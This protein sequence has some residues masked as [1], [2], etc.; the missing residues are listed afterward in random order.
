[1]RVFVTG[2]SGWIGSAVCEELLAHKHEVVG[3]ARTEESAAALAGRGITPHAGSLDDP[4]GLAAALTKTAQRRGIAG[5]VGDG[6]SRWAAVHRSDAASMVR[7]AL[8]KAPAGSRVHAVAEEGIRS[9]DI[10]AAIGNFLGL[11][12]VSVAADDV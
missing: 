10:A 4:E 11:P 2:A 6:S 9:R 1:M 12:A 8:E 3:L 7:L 5:Y